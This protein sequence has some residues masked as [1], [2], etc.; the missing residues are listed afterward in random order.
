MVVPAII[1]YL[2]KFFHESYRWIGVRQTPA[3]H[4]RLMS[5]MVRIFLNILKFISQGNTVTH[6]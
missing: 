4:L 2:F 1:D 5:S 6:S 3:T